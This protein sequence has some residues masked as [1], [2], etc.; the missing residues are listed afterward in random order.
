MATPLPGCAATPIFKPESGINHRRWMRSMGH[1]VIVPP[2]GREQ[3][4]AELHEAHPGISRMKAL[5]RGYV[6]WP[7]MDREL[8]DAVKKCQQCQ[9]HQKAPAEAPLHPWEWPGQPWSRVHIDYAGPYKG[10]MYLVVIDAH[11]KWMDVHIMRSTTSAATIVK[12]REIFATHGLPETIVS[13]NG[14]N[15]TSAEFENFLSKKRHQ[16][17]QSI[18]IPSSFEWPGR[19]SS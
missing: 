12:L 4:I 1:R 18:T 9:L 8:E 11:S 2:Q 10:H 3:V 15:F 16:T 13:D 14:P 5:A 17:H 7:N 19:A 6:W